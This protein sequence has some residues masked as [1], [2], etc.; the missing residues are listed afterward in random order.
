[1]SEGQARTEAGRLESELSEARAGFE[2]AARARDHS[3]HDTDASLAAVRSAQNRMRQAE[4]A[5]LDHLATYD[6]AARAGYVAGR[7]TADRANIA[8]NETIRDTVERAPAP[9]DRPTLNEY[10]GRPGTNPAH[11]TPG[12]YGRDTVLPPAQRAPAAPP[13]PALPTYTPPNP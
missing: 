2:A 7:Q 4:A 5:Y 8:P 12:G 9:A 1:M 3:T 13:T 10:E 11:L 6:P